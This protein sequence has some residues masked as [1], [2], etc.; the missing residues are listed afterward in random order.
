M[1]NGVVVQN[2]QRW[3]GKERKEASEYKA[4]LNQGEREKKKSLKRIEDLHGYT[5]RRKRHKYI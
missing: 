3:K 1:I 4:S 2:V 5:V